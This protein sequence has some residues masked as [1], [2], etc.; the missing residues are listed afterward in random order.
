[1][2]SATK[3]EQAKA[4]AAAPFNYAEYITAKATTPAKP[5]VMPLAAAGP[6]ACL[7]RR[8]IEQ[9]APKHVIDA[10]QE[11]LAMLPE[12]TTTANKRKHDDDDVEDSEDS[13]DSDGAGYGSGSDDEYDREGNSK[14]PKYM[15][16]D[17][18]SD[19]EYDREGNSK[20]AEVHEQGLQLRRK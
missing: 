20:V 1:M 4:K 10:M 5:A 13:G 18:G 8:T 15:S 7:Y 9:G 19:D 2:S 17:Y 11:Y 14:V 12:P 16:K 6:R 3:A